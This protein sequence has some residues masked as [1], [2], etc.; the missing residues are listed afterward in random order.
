LGLKRFAELVGSNPSCNFSYRPTTCLSPPLPWFNWCWAECYWAS[1]FSL[2]PRRK[3]TEEETTPTDPRLVRLPTPLHSTVNHNPTGAGDL[4]ESRDLAAFGK[5]TNRSVAKLISYSFFLLDRCARYLTCRWL[6]KLR[7][8]PLKVVVP[9]YHSGAC[10]TWI[11]WVPTDQARMVVPDKWVR[12]HQ[13]T[14]RP[15]SGS[16]RPGLWPQRPSGRFPHTTLSY[17]FG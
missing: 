11:P 3:I 2:V 7:H 13:K 9:T 17:L 1:L 15:D 6:Y 14:S 4:L 12:P 10:E 16:N 5:I 8:D